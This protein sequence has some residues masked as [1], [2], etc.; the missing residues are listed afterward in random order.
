MVPI[1][2]EPAMIENVR[3]SVEKRSGSTAIL[4]RAVREGCLKVA[5]GVYQLAIGK[6]ERVV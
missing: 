6:I 1:F 2:G 3:I 4:R 5:G